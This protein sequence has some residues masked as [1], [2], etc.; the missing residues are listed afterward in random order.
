MSSKTPNGGFS[1]T[2]GSNYM[3]DGFHFDTEYND[4]VLDGARLPEAKGIAG[5]PRGIVPPDGNLHS[6]MPDGLAVE[7]D[8]NMAELTRDAG[9]DINLV[10]HSWLASQPEPDLKGVRSLEEVIKNMEEGNLND[11]EASNLKALQELWGSASTD[12]TTIIPNTNHKNEPYLNPYRKEQSKLPGDSYREKKEKAYRKLAFDNLDL[13]SVEDKELRGRLS[14]D[15]GLYGKVYIRASH[16]PGIFNGKWDAEINKKCASCMYLIAKGTPFDRFLGME[17]VASVKDISWKKAHSLLKP[18]FEACG[19]EKEAGS[20]YKEKIKSLFSQ[21]SK[22]PESVATQTWFPNHDG[23][24][25]LKKTSTIVEKVDSREHRETSTAQRRLEKIAGQLVSQGFLGESETTK[26]LNSKGTP[27]E[28]INLLYRMA[29]RPSAA[30]DYSGQGES[31]S[32]FN[33][34][35]EKIS[36]E[37]SVPRKEEREYAKRQKSAMLKISQLLRAGEISYEEVGEAIQ[38][39]KTPE[40]KLASVLEVIARPAEQRSYQEYSLTEHRMTKARNKAVEP[41]PS[42][43]KRANANSWKAANAKVDKLLSTGLLGKEQY[44]K[45]SSIEDPN[46]FVRKAFEFAATPSESNVYVGEETA[47]VL[48]HKKSNVVSATEQKVSSWLKRK[49]SEGAVGEELNILL[50]SRFNE[51]VVHEY[52]SKIASL[53]DEH[54]GLSGH[55][56]VDAE[57]YLSNG[58]EGCDKGA[59]IHRANQIPTLL[60]TSKCGSCVFNSQGTCQKYNK[61]IVASVSEVVENPAD[62]KE[63]MIRIA[64]STDSEKIASLFSNTY[65]PNQFNLSSSEHI[66]LNVEAPKDKDL[67]NI[68]FGGFDL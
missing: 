13:K 51:N 10:D 19:I 57:A 35:K 56:Y 60:K 21:M 8:L 36:R 37:A 58:T 26:A 30:S 18:K 31:T 43:E 46:D 50:T 42:R 5:L 63:E 20:S 41:L 16:F 34:K 39:K 52:Q 32:Y 28:K 49:M 68:L 6:D 44:E 22:Q 62:Y 47:H 55:A 2:N 1:L 64:N 29:S 27:T 25:N 9:Q 3:L 24:S 66:Q 65:D 54:E 7:A 38:G 45:I 40:D 67:G 53:R 17:V 4:G 14:K 61:V 48:G 11:P 15:S 23:T 59:L 12:G 33:M